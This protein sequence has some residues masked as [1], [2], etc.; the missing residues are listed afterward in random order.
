M[1]FARARGAVEQK[2]RGEPPTLDKLAP[3]LLCLLTHGSRWL[4]VDVT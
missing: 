1:A 3:L 4:V 2:E